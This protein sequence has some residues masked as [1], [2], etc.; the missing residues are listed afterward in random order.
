MYHDLRIYISNIVIRS[1]TNY[2]NLTSNCRNKRDLLL[3]WNQIWANHALSII[4]SRLM[5]RKNTGIKRVVIW[6]LTSHKDAIW[7]SGDR[8]RFSCSKYAMD[9]TFR[10][11]IEGIFFRSESKATLTY[12]SFLQIVFHGGQNW[13]E[14]AE[15]WTQSHNREGMSDAF[16][17]IYLSVHRMTFSSFHPCR[18][19]QPILS[20]L[21]RPG[22]L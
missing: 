21:H 2:L 14:M 6:A 8:C 12:D 20:R 9:P 7:N 4:F 3:L 15:P 13:L 19:S 10:V 18:S 22:W 5:L 17:L 16:Y 11:D 1:G